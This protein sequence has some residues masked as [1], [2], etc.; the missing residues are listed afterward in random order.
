MQNA[1]PNDISTTVLVLNVTQSTTSTLFVRYQL[2]FN[3]SCRKRCQM[4]ILALAHLRF[5]SLIINLGEISSDDEVTGD[6]SKISEYWANIRPYVDNPPTIFGVTETDLPDGCQIEQAHVLHR[7][8]ARYPTSDPFDGGNI[9]RFAEKINQNTKN[10]LGPL[11]FL[12]TWSLQLGEELLVPNGYNAEMISGIDFRNEYGHILNNAFS[13]S[14]LRTS[15][16][17][18]NYQSTIAWATGYF[19]SSNSTD[20]Y[21][22]LSLG[23]QN[24]S[25]NTLYGAL[26]CQNLFIPT[27]FTFNQDEM[28]SY[29]APVLLNATIRFNNNTNSTFIFD[30]IDAFAMQSLCAYE[31]SALNSSDFCSLFTLNEWRGF[32]QTLNLAFYNVYAFGNET[33]R[34]Q[35]IGY[36][37]ELL[38]RF[39]HRLINISHSSVN[40]TLDSSQ[41]TFPLNQSFYLDMSHDNNIASVLT[42]LSIDYFREDLS[43]TFPP[44]ND[45]HYRVSRMT[46]FSARMVT[47]KIRCQSSSFVRMKLNKGILPLNSIRGGFC[48]RERQDGLCSIE[49]FLASQTNASIMAN[50]DYV[51]FGNYTLDKNVRIT[52]GTLFP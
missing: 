9:K 5:A 44:P 30:H 17:N 26:A 34:A 51:C 49:N 39:Q 46:P 20:Q 14:L 31:Y 42:A 28:Y 33:G 22:I 37:E 1:L 12:N 47:E 21:S 29:L 24:G 23:Y 6:I 38:A 7:H 19:G 3:R 32:E 11:A 13:K 50:F 10:F 4:Q 27:A 41:T 45:Q 40:S 48:S 2:V 52:D 18:R 15:G 16:V 35:G 25:N 8:G 43:Q 36:V